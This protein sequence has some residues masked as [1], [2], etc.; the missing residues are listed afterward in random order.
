MIKSMTG[1][2][3][4]KGVSGKIEISVELKSVNNRYLDCTVKMPR[5]FAAFEEPL[6]STV[7]KNISR[8]KVDVYIS[9]DSSNADDVEIKVN[10]S[11]AEAYI[12]ALKDLADEYGLPVSTFNGSSKLSVLELVRFPDVLKAEKREAD[13]EEL[14][15]SISAVLENALQSFNDM[16]TREGERLKAD[17]S[18]RI[19]EIRRLT[20]MAEE[21]SPKTVAEY[22]KKLELRMQQVLQSTEVDEARILTEAAIFAE[23]VAIN[24]EVVRLKSHTE[25]LKEMLESRDPIGRKMDFLVQELNRE[26]NTIGSKGNNAEM[27]RIIVDMKAEIEKIR[28]Q[29]QNIE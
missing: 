22:T 5:M 9:I 28:E 13:Q 4:A 8:G 15:L 26:A 3:A 1:Y 11:L 16:R 29:A 10:R 20:E 25:Q 2:G 23:R 21:I 12:T 6:K 27:A 14:L 19:A 17:I 18:A 7:Q 24:E